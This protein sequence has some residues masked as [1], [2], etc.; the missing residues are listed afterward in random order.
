MKRRNSYCF[1]ATFI[2]LSIPLYNEFFNFSKIRNFDPQFF[3]IF[4]CPHTSRNWVSLCYHY[5]IKD[6]KLFERFWRKVWRGAGTKCYTVLLYRIA[7][8]YSATASCTLNSIKSL[9]TSLQSN[10]RE[11]HRTPVRSP[12]RWWVHHMQFRS[13]TDIWNF[14]AWCLF[15]YL[16]C[17][18]KRDSNLNQLQCVGSDTAVW[19]EV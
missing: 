7:I 8:P 1:H 18:V 15:N 2:F 4:S 5:S 6:F 19:S 12:G 3:L 17:H 10:L 14:Y 11:T 13:V 16:W 9:L